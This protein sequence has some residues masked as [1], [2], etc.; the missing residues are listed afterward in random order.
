MVNRPHG[1][2]CNLHFVKNGNNS[3]MQI[4][5]GRPRRATSAL[6]P[7]TGA[8]AASASLQ[9]GL[10][11]FTSAAVRMRMRCGVRT[12]EEPGRGSLGIL[13]PGQGPLFYHCLFPPPPRQTW[14]LWMHVV[15]LEG[16][17]GRG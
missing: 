1:L 13:H 6:P 5:S 11:R 16:G 12:S 8:A 14:P 9:S 10:G 15:G 17:G 7:S 3:T 4:A 2:S